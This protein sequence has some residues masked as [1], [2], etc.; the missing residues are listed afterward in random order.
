MDKRYFDEAGLAFTKCENYEKALV[1]YKEALNWQSMLCSAMQL[2]YSDDK[3]I[4][5]CKEAAGL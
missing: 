4:A 2:S 5:L 1:A 3:I